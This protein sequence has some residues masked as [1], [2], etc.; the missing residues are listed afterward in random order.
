MAKFSISRSLDALGLAAIAL[1]PTCS[2]LL[3]EKATSYLVFPNIELKDA[4]LLACVSAL[5]IALFGLRTLAFIYRWFQIK[6]YYQSVKIEYFYLADGTVITRTNFNYVNGWKRTAYLSEE[7]LIWH[8]PI[9][10]NDI[11]Y[12]LFQRGELGDRE[13]SADSETNISAVPQLAVNATDHRYSW[14]P[15]IFPALRAKE[16]VSFIVEIISEKTEI[17]AFKGG[18]KFGFGFEIPCLDVSLTAYAPFGHRFALIEPRISVRR[19][20]D[21]TEIAV[22]RRKKPMP[23]I[24][25]DGTI[26]TL[27]V[28]RAK[29]GRRFWVH[30]KFER[31]KTRNESV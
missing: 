2:I 16:R 23:E 28:A 25:P 30:Y 9:G 15:R 3:P 22:A 26:A 17:D 6:P 19:S 7:S 13:I 27:K 18:T 4:L 1:A 31:Q 21:L 8:Q 24:S 12:R 20:S 14:K 10:E 11:L 5:G 29:A